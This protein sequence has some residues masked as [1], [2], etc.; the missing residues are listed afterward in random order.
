MK[1]EERID[2]PDTRYCVRCGILESE[3]KRDGFMGCGIGWG[4]NYP[5]HIYT[6]ENEL[7][8]MLWVEDK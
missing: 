7:N 3:V 4:G 8:D 6:T 5:K 1:I 2:E